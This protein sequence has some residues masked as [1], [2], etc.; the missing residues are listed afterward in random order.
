MKILTY[1][2]IESRRR[3]IRN[4]FYYVLIIRNY[5]SIGTVV[6]IQAII[7]AM[8]IINKF[9]FPL[10]SAFELC[11]FR[12]LSIVNCVVIAVCVQVFVC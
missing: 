4:E 7:L 11:S 12:K 3:G 1:Y 9:R 5:K 2:T 6:N 8:A 10:I